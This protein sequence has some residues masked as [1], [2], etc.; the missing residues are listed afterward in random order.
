MGS[1]DGC[2]L[3]FA[4]DIQQ[5][6]SAVLTFVVARLS[7]AIFQIRSGPQCCAQEVK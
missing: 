1:M 7:M 3:Q 4:T 5:A 2:N 6:R